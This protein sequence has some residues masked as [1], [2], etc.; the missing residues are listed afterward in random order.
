MAGLQGGRPPTCRYILSTCVVVDD[1]Q[2]NTDVNGK[3]V[4]RME[5]DSSVSSIGVVGFF[6][7]KRQIPEQHRP[8][9]IHRLDQ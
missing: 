6:G 5:I 8:L 3:L 2:T 4:Q 1:G 7:V 9:N